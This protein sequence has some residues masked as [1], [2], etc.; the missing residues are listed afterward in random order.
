MLKQANIVL[1]KERNKDKK[2][3]PKQNLILLSVKILQEN[4]MRRINYF[5]IIYHIITLQHHATI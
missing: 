4:M 1:R 3:T 2:E 5:M